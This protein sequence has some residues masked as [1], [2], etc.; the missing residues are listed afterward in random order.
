MAMNGHLDVVEFLH[1][2]REEGCTDQAMI[3]AAKNG[4]LGVVEFLH[5]RVEGVAE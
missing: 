2:T 4:H 5:D 1:E 3:W